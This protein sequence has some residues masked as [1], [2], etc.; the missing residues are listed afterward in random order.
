M[1]SAAILGIFLFPCCRPFSCR[2]PNGVLLD[3]ELWR[4]PQM[5]LA[6]RQSEVLFVEERNEYQR[7]S[8]PEPASCAITIASRPPKLEGQSL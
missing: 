6:T 5:N 4:A 1:K 3:C 7:V 2:I 8:I